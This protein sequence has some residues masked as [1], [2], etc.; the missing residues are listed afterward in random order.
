MTDY[1][2]MIQDCEADLAVIERRLES[3]REL[4]ALR[5]KVRDGNLDGRIS[6]LETIQIELKYNIREYAKRDKL[7]R[8]RSHT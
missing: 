3:L 8:E 4:R 1:A 6:A 7:Q 2:K 5:R